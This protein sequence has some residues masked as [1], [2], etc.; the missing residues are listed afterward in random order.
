MHRRLQLAQALGDGAITGGEA[1]AAVDD[2]DDGVGLDHC[3][4]G[5][6]RHLDEDALRRARLETAGVDRDEGTRTVARLSVMPVARHARHVV[7]DGVA[8]SREAVKERRLADVRP[9]DDGD[10]RLHS[11]RA[12]SPPSTV[13]TRIP[14][15]SARG[16]ARTAPLAPPRAM[17]S[18]LSRAMK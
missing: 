12:T 3:L 11:A 15:P 13:C 8:A 9:A 1:G 4:F 17:N 10:D 2:E 14:A 18:P 16:V 5:L 6:A 7:H